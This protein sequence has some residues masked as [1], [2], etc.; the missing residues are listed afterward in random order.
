[1]WGKVI[2]SGLH[3]IGQILNFDDRREFQNQGIEHFHAPMHV[4]NAPSIDEDDKTATEFVDKNITCSLP[5]K[6]Q[7]SEFHDLVKKVQT[8]HHSPTCKKTN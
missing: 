2:L 5:D 7:F 3:P 4:V 6:S 8:H 1:M